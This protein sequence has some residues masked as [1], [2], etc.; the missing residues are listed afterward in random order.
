MKFVLTSTMLW[1][2]LVISSMATAQEQAINGMQ[3]MSGMN[4]MPNMQAMPHMSVQS[5]TGVGT[6]NRVDWKSGT[7]NLTHGPIKGLGW[8]GM[9]MTFAVSDN[10][11]LDGISPGEK[12]E[13]EVAKRDSGQFS[14][15]HI[16]PVK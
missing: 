13:F 12:V 15:V 11:L 9:T 8:P 5:N 6:V 4:G 1:I 3:G 7:I 14:I 10:S 2:F 16:T